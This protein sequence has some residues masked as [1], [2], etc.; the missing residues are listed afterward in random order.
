MHPSGFL[1]DFFM[2]KSPEIL[3][4]KS[5]I[6][7]MLTGFFYFNPVSIFHFNTFILYLF[8]LYT[9]NKF[10]DKCYSGTCCHTVFITVGY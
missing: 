3:K 6:T 2:K 8:F 10:F 9:F 5:H 4:S 1:W 7:K